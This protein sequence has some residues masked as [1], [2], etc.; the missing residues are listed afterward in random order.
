[1]GHTLT[2]NIPETVYES[3]AEKAEQ[4]G[5]PPETFAAQL[6]VTATQGGVDDPLEPF[7]GAFS[8]R[9]SDWADHHDEHLGVSVQETM[10]R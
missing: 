5:Q 3:L 10:R 2:L 6:L 4:A 8:S 9:G 7:L 1:M